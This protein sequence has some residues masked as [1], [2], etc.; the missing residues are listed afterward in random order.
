MDLQKGYTFSGTSPNNSVTAEKLNTLVD[1]ATI[2]TGFYTGRTENTAANSS[3]FALLYDSVNGEYRKIQIGNLVPTTRSRTGFQN[4]YATTAAAQQI[5]VTA[6]EIL[7][8]S[9]AGQL[10]Y[11]RGF[12]ALADL[13]LYTGGPTPGGRDAASINTAGTQWYYYWAISD[14]ALDKLLLSQSATSPTLPAGY[15]YRTLLGAVRIDNAGSFIRFVQR[16]L[17]FATDLASAASTTSSVLNP[18]TGATPA[19][20]TNIA[21]A[22]ARTLQTADLSRCIPPNLTARVRGLIGSTDTSTPYVYA[23]CPEGATSLAAGPLEL[24][25]GLQ[26]FQTT[27]A[28][29]GATML[30]FGNAAPFDLL[31]KTSQQ[32]SWACHTNTSAHHSLRVTGYQLSL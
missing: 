4:L 1:G 26:L 28:A 23:L 7:M 24:L 8:R 16:N 18:Y 19:E 21:P 20:F 12:V 27:G 9:D 25:E 6:G 13:S 10:H 31:V 22:A 30:G 14:G 3:D 2:L 17:D 11:A 32:I 29:S 5:S 15:L